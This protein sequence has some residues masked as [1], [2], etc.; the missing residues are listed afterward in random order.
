MTNTS[1][2]QRVLAFARVGLVA[3]SGQGSI[4][5]EISH[6]TAWLEKRGVEVTLDET[7]GELSAD[8]TRICSRVELPSQVDLVIALGGDGTLLSVA[9]FAAEAATPVLGINYGNLGFLTLTPREE[10]YEVLEQVFSGQFISS[11]RMMLRA[12]IERADGSVVTWDVLND[13]VVNKTSLAR[14]IEYEV[15]VDGDFVSRYRADGLIVATPTGSTAYSLSAG[16]PLI[17]PEMDA[18]VVCPISPHSL[19]N[20]PLV[21]PADAQIAVQLITSDQDIVLTLDGQE[22]A[23]FDHR[24][25]TKIERCPHRFE[26]LSAG[27]RAHFEVLR[28]KLGWGVDR[29]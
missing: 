23:T 15:S 3:K 5:N 29:K 27:E 18:V 11:S 25:V 2:D 19:A 6:I 8:G 20:R 16:G 7:A 26:L 12:S 28:T 14:I 4:G 1:A 21:V 17:M 24:E 22:G 9:R 10:I 13:A